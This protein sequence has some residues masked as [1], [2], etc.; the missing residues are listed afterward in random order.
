MD[1]EKIKAFFVN[2][3]EKVILAVIVGVAGYLI[4]QG[5]T[6]AHFTDEHDPEQVITRAQ[7]VKSSIDEDHTQAV[8]GEREPTLDILARARE[9]YNPVDGGLYKLN[10]PWE[11]PGS[12]RMTV[13]RRDPE[14]KAPRA[15]T[16]TPVATLIAVQGSN[17]SDDYALAEIRLAAG[18]DEDDDR[19]RRRGGRG[20]DR[21]EEQNDR[22]GG[23]GGLTLDGANRRGTSERNEPRASTAA[24]TTAFDEENN[25]GVQPRVADERHPKP[26]ATRFIAGAAVVPHKE[27]F[28]AYNLALRDAD[29][30]NSRRDA[31]LYVDFE[32]QRADVT[33]KPADQL[34]DDDWKDIWN[35]SLYAQLAAKIWST[36][37]P[38]IVPVD[39]RDDYLSNWIPPVLLDDYRDFITHP[40]IPLK[41]P[42][43]LE[44]EQDEEVVEDTPDDRGLD[45]FFGRP[46]EEA[47]EQPEEPAA[48]AQNENDSLDEDY[49][50]YKL[51][52]FYDFGNLRRSSPQPGRAYVYRVRFAVID[53]NYPRDLEDQPQ[54]SSL[55]PEVAQRVLALDEQ[56]RRTDQRPF[57]RWSPWSEPSPPV[58]LPSMAHYFVGPVDGDSIGTLSIGGKRVR[59]Y[60][61]PPVADAVAAAYDSKYG[62]RVTFPMKVIA[63]SVLSHQGETH[64]VDPV[65]MEMVKLEDAKVVSSATVIDI[66]GGDSLEIA[67]DLQ[68]PGMMLLYDDNGDLVVADEVHDLEMY[69]IY[70]FPDLQDD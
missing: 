16:V 27:L 58:S 1:T 56:A 17:K 53:P 34:T 66:S 35:L 25:F 39:Y 64:V 30:Y 15:V 40:L 67:D 43:E 48:E 20:R 22:R 12:N 24:V 14:L 5:F 47:A 28:Q 26:Q 55:A 46:T 31:P 3:S 52:R 18:E 38:D 69:N 61:K 2:H 13:R 62:T 36:V 65:A 54:L 49:V 33:E 59:Y 50:E 42:A 29:E 6:L 8:I 37:A 57:R 45:D 4:F 70:S 68:Q 44:L 60:R 9:I 41:S 21:D 19:N 32:V 51:L 23:L 63:G 7:Q 11:P 10:N